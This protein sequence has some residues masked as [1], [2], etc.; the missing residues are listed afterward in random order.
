MFIIVAVL[1]PKNKSISCEFIKTFMNSA[2]RDNFEIFLFQI[3]D[4]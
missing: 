1:M 2:D 3:K 4:F